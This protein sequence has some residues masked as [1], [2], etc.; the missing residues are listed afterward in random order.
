MPTTQTNKKIL[1]LK[2]WEFCTP[3]ATATG[4]GQCADLSR[5]VQQNVLLLQSATLAR[6]YSVEEDGWITLPSPALTG[7]PLDGSGICAGAWSTG[8][9]VGASTL[10]AS[11][12]ST[13][14]ITTNQT[15][16]RDL[17][18][19]PI[20]IVSGPNA[21]VT[22]TI[23]SNTLGANAVITVPAQASAFTN[24]TVY[25]LGTPTW[26]VVCSGTQSAGTFRKYD[27]ATNT[28]TTLSQT[29]LP[30]LGTDGVLVA[31]PSWQWTDYLAFATG[32]ATAGGATTITNSAKSWATNQWAN[33]QIR[34]VSGT[35]AGQIRTVASN[36]GTV[37]TVSAAWATNPDATSQYS[38][39]GNDDFLYYIG[40]N[41]VTLYRYSISG[42]AWSTITPTVA[43][44]GAATAG[45][46]GLWVSGSPDSAWTSESAIINGRRIYSHRGVSLDYYDIAANAW[47]SVGPAPGN[48]TFAAGSQYAYSGRYLYS[49]LNQ[50]GRW[51]RYD[52]VTNDT[53]G[54]TT[55]LYTQA[56]AVTGSRCWVARYVDGNTTIE[57]VYFVLNSLTVLLRQMV[58]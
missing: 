50:T 57:Y 54:W 25:R 1:D 47:T 27:Y 20:H 3:T 13:T 42:N 39:E 6:L 55:A 46:S 9:T 53:V 17:R 43:R 4:A 48:E 30:T 5:H 2:R 10:T 56:T 32:T 29:G 7:S 41:A 34:I 26:Y 22:L 36:T 11:A 45:L 8:T 19:Y 38:L 24:A 49:Q 12:G 51:F 35:G 37:I 16:A 40:N 23:S 28:W 15:L 31:T 21:G 14:T 44:A 33:Y 18:G 58:I 52:V